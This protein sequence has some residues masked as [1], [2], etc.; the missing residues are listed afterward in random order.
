MTQWEESSAGGDPLKD[1]NPLATHLDSLYVYLEYAR[2]N[3]QVFYA[4][5]I[6][7]WCV[8]RHSDIKNVLSDAGTYSSAEAFVRPRGLPPVVDRVASW[9]W[10]ETPGITY[11]DPPAHHRV[12]EVVR[13]G[14][15][16]AAITA[17]EPTVRSIV[18]QHVGAIDGREEVD[19]AA[20]LTGSMPLSVIMHIIGIPEIMH[21][22][23]KGWLQDIFTI[24]AG[25]KSAS[26]EELTRCAEGH[27]QWVDY[28]TGLV[29]EKMER[30]G[31]DLISFMTAAGNPAQRLS[32]DEIARQVT[33]LISA[34]TETTG[35]ALTNTLHTLLKQPGLWAEVCAGNLDIPS[36]AA[37]GLRHDTPVI[38]MFR[39]SNRESVLS[40][41]TIPARSR[42]LLL[43]A[44][45]NHDE[46][47]FARPEEFDPS[48]PT[49]SKHLSFGYGIHFCVG[50]RL[51]ELE[52]T[53]TL[54]ALAQRFPLMRLVSEEHPGYKPLS[55]FRELRSLRVLPY[56]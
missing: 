47:L 53:L 39:R 41:A 18:E 2:R 27:R 38:G 31:D 29:A 45:A 55:Q 30:P 35:S 28:L 52:I 50:A 46:D 49:S 3:E 21:Q 25:S 4:P 8:T 12:R 17:L 26:D 19:L 15:T 7:A 51:A 37:E 22:T 6:D 56:G 42:L 40:G 32:S 11:L 48:R 54:S 5:A 1:F 36:V 44:S 9:L 23:V 16:P 43:F 13:K 34:G 33:V 14:F 24:F 20:A 10:D